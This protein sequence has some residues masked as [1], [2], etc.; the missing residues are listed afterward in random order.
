MDDNAYSPPKSD[1]EIDESRRGS[2]LKAILAGTAIDLF[3]SLLVGIVIAIVYSAYLASQGLD[4]SE[5]QSALSTIERFTPIWFI[6]MSLGGAISVFAG[7]ICA[8]M[9]NHKEYKYCA[10]LGGISAASAVLLNV[11]HY[12]PLETI[13]LIALS[14]AC[15]L[16]GAWLHVS[17]KQRRG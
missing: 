2:P 9:T 16:F 15:V 4:E 8:S 17:G 1:I 14:F 12:V 10:I 13:V 11:G 6:G 7:Y 5:I 3:G